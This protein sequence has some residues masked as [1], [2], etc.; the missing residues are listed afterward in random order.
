MNMEQTK[1]TFTCD[2]IHELRVRVAEQYSKMTPEEAEE[3]FRFHVE[4]A[5][6]TIAEL[7]KQREEQAATR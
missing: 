2:D 4:R 3:D 5:E 7:R 6:R 1:K